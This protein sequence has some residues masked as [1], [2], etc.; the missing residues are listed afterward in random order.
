MTGVQ[1]CALPISKEFV[2]DLEELGKDFNSE[3][4]KAKRVAYKASYTKD[5]KKK[6]HDAWVLFIRE[7]SRNV[8]FFIY[9]ERYY[10]QHKQFCLSTKTWTIV[11]N[12]L[13]RNETSNPTPRQPP[14]KSLPNNP[15]QSKDTSALDIVARKLEEQTIAN[16]SFKL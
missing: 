15:S 8:P 3:E 10:G 2:P 14:V 6:V 11:K 9:F 1:T 7:I 4:N 16:F 5:Q 12:N 13:A